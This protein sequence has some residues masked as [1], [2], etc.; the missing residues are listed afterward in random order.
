MNITKKMHKFNVILVLICCLGCSAC[1]EDINLN[2]GGSSA[3]PAS[4][5]LID[6]A[7]EAWDD[8][9]M[10]RAENL[11]A[12]AT[13]LT[14]PINEQTES[15]ERYALAAARNGRPNNALDALDQ[16]DA[17]MP[18]ADSTNAWQSAWLNSVRLLAPSVAV[19]RAQKTWSNAS[20]SPNARAQAAIILMGRSW[21]AAQTLPMLPLIA[22]YFDSKDIAQKQNIEYI[23]SEELRYTTGQNITALAQSVAANPN[24]VFPANM[25]LLENARRGLPISA[26]AEARLKDISLYADPALPQR[27]LNVPL[28]SSTD[29]ATASPTANPSAQPTCV[30]LALPASGN[31]VPISTKIRAGADAA[32]T[33]LAQSG[34]NVQIQHI[35]TSQ[36]DW[37]SQLQAL[38]PQCV[39]V[40]GPLQATNFNAAKTAQATAMRSFFTFLPTLE[41]QDEGSLAW[42][43]FPSPQDQVN[44]LLSFTAGMGIRSYGSFYPQDNY[45]TRMNSIFNEAVQSMGATVQSVG[46]APDNVASWPQAA[47][48]LLNPR[49]VNSVPLST[50]TFEAVFLPDSWKNMD[51]ITSAFLYNGDD[52]QVL[53]GTSLWEQSLMSGTTTA[54]TANYK[55]AVF[56]GAWNPKQV[57]QA[58]IATGNADFWTGLGYDFVRFGSALGL[59]SQVSVADVNA[60]IQSAQNI[61]WSMAPITWD[62]LGKASQRLYLF[63]LSQSGIMPADAVLFNQIRLQA[64]NDFNVRQNAAGQPITSPPVTSSATPSPPPAPITAPPASSAPVPAPAPTTVPAQ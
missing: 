48:T 62:S 28:T 33:E 54:N 64:I 46:Y 51:L 61:N 43:F 55:L 45:G 2:F 24:F 53:L 31:I 42:R 23:T 44:S 8:N 38:P 18:D 17:V 11:Y 57:P 35:D 30:I 29:T 1:L 52:K 56:P 60:R 40:G 7:R 21:S 47:A 16:W 26:Q 58:L 59:S 22:R 5:P 3:P 20:N 49:K 13:K 34:V 27:I 6:E 12:K 63:T 10:Q 50:A 4:D 32:A 25:I 41:G 36:A 9:D 15:F 19:E 39:V 37:L 14:L